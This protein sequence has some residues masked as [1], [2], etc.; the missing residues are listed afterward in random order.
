MEGIELS[1]QES[2][3]T[4]EEKENKYLRISEADSKRTGKQ[5]K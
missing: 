2:N 5:S 1:N 3:R 4:L